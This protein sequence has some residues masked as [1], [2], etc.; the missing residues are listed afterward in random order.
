MY[1][2]TGYRPIKSQVSV[3]RAIEFAWLKGRQAG[4]QTE[5]TYVQPGRLQVMHDA[6][7]QIQ[8]HAA[9]WLPAVVVMRDSSDEANKSHCGHG[10]TYI[11]HA[12]IRLHALCPVNIYHVYFSYIMSTFLISC[13]YAAIVKNRPAGL[14][15]RMIDMFV[16]A[17]TAS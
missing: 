9:A 6:L 14:Q 1:M 16:T 8:F 2:M 3:S 13:V 17:A 11:E 15:S 4:T 10:R 12:G 5:T 7:M